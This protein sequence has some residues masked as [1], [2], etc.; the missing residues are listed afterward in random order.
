MMGD[1]AARAWRLAKLSTSPHQRDDDN[2]GVPEGALTR[3]LR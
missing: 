2:E 3:A 1:V